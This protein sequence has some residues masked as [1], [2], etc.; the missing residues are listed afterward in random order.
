MRAVRP[1]S[2][3]PLGPP[4]PF[5]ALAGLLVAWLAP[6]PFGARA[7]AAPQAYEEERAELVRTVEREMES[8]RSYHRREGLDPAV[9]EALAAVPRHRFVPEDQRRWAYDNRPLPIGHGQTISQPYIVAL[10]TDLLDLEPDDRVLE[11]GTGS[12]YQAAILGEIVD[13]VYTIEVVEPLHQR[14]L[15]LLAELGYDQ[16]ETR[17]GDG[18]YGWPEAAPFDAIIVTA[19]ASHVPPPLLEQLASPGRMMIPVGSRFMVQQLVLVTKSADGEISLEQILPVRFV[20]L[21]GDH[22]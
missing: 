9:V 16:I 5:V 19:A 1:Q 17:L 4:L 10:M 20:P 2:P 21:T 13:Q 7:T 8:T 11:I 6:V 14:S 22:E 15:A 3:E 18:Y 12:G